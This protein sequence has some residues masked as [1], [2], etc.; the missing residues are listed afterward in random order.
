MVPWYGSQ[1]REDAHYVLAFASADRA[2]K[3]ISRG[4]PRWRAGK[5]QLRALQAETEMAARHE[6]AAS[7]RDDRGQRMVLSLHEKREVVGIRLYSRM[8]QGAAAAAAH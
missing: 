5:E 8:R 6:R 4:S 2:A 7:T 3:H 1:S